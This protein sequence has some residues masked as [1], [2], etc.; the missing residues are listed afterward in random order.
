MPRGEG[1][2]TLVAEDEERV[3]SLLIK[4][5][6]E[7]GYNVRSAADGQEALRITKKNSEG[8][9]LA[10]FDVVMPGM[11]GKAANLR[12]RIAPPALPV[13]LHR[14]RRGHDG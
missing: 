11:G 13:V 10:I 2:T 14:I 5:L 3:R 4:L 7:N 9:D 1:E 8:I 6:G 12:A